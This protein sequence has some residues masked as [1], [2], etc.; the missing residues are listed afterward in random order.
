MRDGV[1]RP[2]VSADVLYNECR[3]G[4]GDGLAMPLDRLRFVGAGDRGTQATFPNETPFEYRPFAGQSFECND[5]ARASLCGYNMLD[6]G[7]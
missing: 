6:L 1:V 5:A 3:P 4:L 7:I 2:P